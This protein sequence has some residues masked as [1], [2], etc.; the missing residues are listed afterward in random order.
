MIENERENETER[1]RERERE[2]GGGEAGT[3]GKT[4]DDSTIRILALL[5]S[6]KINDAQMRKDLTSG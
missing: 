3:T 4:I 6:R 2:G 5:H 1:E